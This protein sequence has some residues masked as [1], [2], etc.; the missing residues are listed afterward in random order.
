MNELMGPPDID[1][2]NCWSFPMLFIAW[3]DWI[4]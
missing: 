2:G 3:W 4:G 1:S